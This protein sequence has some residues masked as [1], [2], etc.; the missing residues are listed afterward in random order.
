MKCFEWMLTNRALN[1]TNLVPASLRPGKGVPCHGKVWKTP[2]FPLPSWDSTLATGQLSRAHPT[3]LHCG[4]CALY[5]IGSHHTICS[6][7]SHCPYGTYI[8]ILFTFYCPCLNASE[9]YLVLQAFGH[10]ARK[11][12]GPRPYSLWFETPLIALISSPCNSVLNYKGPCW[13]GSLTFQR[14]LAS[15]HSVT[16]LSARP[17]PLLRTKQSLWLSLCLLCTLQC[18][19]QGML[20]PLARGP[21]RTPQGNFP[22]PHSVENLKGCC[23]N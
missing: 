4:C 18:L 10:C 16:E 23:C 19:W 13:N 6:W 11:P 1:S 12:A 2:T 21:G 5:Q 20:F 17:L 14:Q 8:S 22:A 9:L 3:L 7:I 15:S